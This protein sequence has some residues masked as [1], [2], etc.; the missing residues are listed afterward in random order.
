MHSQNMVLEQKINRRPSHRFWC[1]T[2]H[3]K[4]LSEA[5]MCVC[6]CECTLYANNHGQF[7]GKRCCINQIKEIINDN[8]P[9]FCNQNYSNRSEIPEIPKLLYSFNSHHERLYSGMTIKYV[10]K[11]ESSLSYPYLNIIFIKTVSI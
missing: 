9:L 2:A 5:H 1:Y 11:Q 6:V 8:K 10:S 3:S 7:G 4:A